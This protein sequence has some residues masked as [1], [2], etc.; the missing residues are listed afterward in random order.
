MFDNK[1]DVTTKY[2]SSLITKHKH[3]TKPIKK[4]KLKVNTKY[5]YKEYIAWKKTPQ[6]NKWK[7]KQFLKQG[8]L[9]FYCQEFLPMTRQN[10]EHKTA[11]SL[12]GK[13]NLN[14]L[15]L[16]CSNCNKNKG[17]SVLSVG[18][19]TRLN[20]LNKN[21]KG[22]YL[23]NKEHFTKLYGEYTEDAILNKLRQLN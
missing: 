12:G 11:M 3:K 14:N 8:G 6:F 17:S 10:V 18:E 4:N 23:I 20:K 16:A 19:R 21:H 2:N 9:C 1:V 5:V 22:T 13:N 7:R 15:V